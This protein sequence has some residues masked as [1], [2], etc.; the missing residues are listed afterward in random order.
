[1]TSVNELYPRVQ[2]LKFDLQQQLKEVEAKRMSHSDLQIG[3]D[4]LGHQAALLENL[5]EKEVNRRD[6]WRAKIREIVETQRWLEERLQRWRQHHDKAAVEKAERNELFGRT[7][8][9]SSVVAALDEEGES[10]SRSTNT[11][12]SLIEN[13]SASMAELASQRELLKGAQ[14]RVLDMLTTLG[15]SSST[16]RVIERRNVVDR[17]IVFGGMLIVTVCLF[18]LWRWVR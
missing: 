9:P 13:A 17:A 6:E 15:V 4:A 18:L 1:M 11:V 12:S 14:R 2:K 16:I 8:I 10:Y 5:A 3:L 7:Q